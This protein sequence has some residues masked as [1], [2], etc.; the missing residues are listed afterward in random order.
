M[1]VSTAQVR[2]RAR[3]LRKSRNYSDIMKLLL[4]R[5]LIA[6][7]CALSI[8]SAYW[9]YWRKHYSGE[10]LS[11]AVT[12]VDENRVRKLLAWCA[13]L[14]YREPNSGQTPLHI[15]CLYSG[16]SEWRYKPY[17]PLAEMLIEAGADVNVREEEAGGTP[18]MYAAF[19]NQVDA[20]K[21]LLHADADIETPD[22]QGLTALHWAASGGSKESVIILLHAG[23][24]PLALTNDG[25]T[26]LDC[27]L[28][29]LR[30]TEGN[31][32]EL[33]QNVVDILSMEMEGK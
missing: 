2:N 4:L 13:E 22:Y 6:V 31:E 23:A 30:S 8:S 19:V 20:V 21:A 26:P 10:A 14:N 5:I 24:N 15:A 25:E 7:V 9:A 28:Q 33:Y 32:K 29:G 27:A 12:S 17:V 16:L 18:L 11:L 1:G 3:P